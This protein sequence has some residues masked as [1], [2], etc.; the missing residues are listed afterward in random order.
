MLLNILLILV[1][2]LVLGIIC[3]GEKQPEERSS[4]D[5]AGEATES[6]SLGDK[7]VEKIE[8]SGTVVGEN[9][10]NLTEKERQTKLKTLGGQ[11]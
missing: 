5:R 8:N 7:T 6:G 4:K 2:V 3:Q 1:I 10:K 11:A 9:P